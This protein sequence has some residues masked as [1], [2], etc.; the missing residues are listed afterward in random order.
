MRYARIAKGGVGV[1]DRNVYAPEA[2]RNERLV[3][4]RRCLA[5]PTVAWLER[6]VARR[7]T[8]L[9]AR[10]ATSL[11]LGERSRLSVRPALLLVKAL[12]QHLDPVSGDDDAAHPKKASA[13]CDGV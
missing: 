7:L 9:L 10:H 3:A 2:A 13:A 1:H 12:G 6:H 4:R 5:R 8:H 11:C